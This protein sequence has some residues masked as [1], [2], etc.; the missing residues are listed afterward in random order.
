MRRIAAVVTIMALAVLPVGGIAWAHHGWSWT[1]GGN[2]ELTGIV[3]TAKLGM[4]MKLK[5]R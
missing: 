2:I 5:K 3:K 4:N 1:T